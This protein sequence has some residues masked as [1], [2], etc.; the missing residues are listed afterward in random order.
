MG[1]LSSPEQIAS[2]VYEAATDGKDQIRYVA[3]NDAKYLYNERLKLGN[4]QFRKDI[5]K[6]FFDK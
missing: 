5:D 1:T 3:G 6:M 4:E 2:I